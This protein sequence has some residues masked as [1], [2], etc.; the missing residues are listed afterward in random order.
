MRVSVIVPVRW[1]HPR[2]LTL[3]DALRAQAGAEAEL[4]A[5]VMDSGRGR[6]GDLDLLPELAHRAHLITAAPSTPAAVR[7]LAATQAQGEFLVFIDDDCVP[8]ADWLERLLAAA[9][10]PSVGAV[11]G[12]VLPAPAT[13]LTE[14]Y[15]GAYGLPLPEDAAVYDRVIPFVSFGHSANLLVRRS[16]FNTLGGFAADWPTG[17]DHDF[18]YRLIKAGHKL[19]FVPAAAVRHFHRATVGGML[20]QAY[21]YGRG[22]VRLLKRHWPKQYLCFAPGKPPRLR[23]SFFTIWLDKT[24]VGLQRKCFVWIFLLVAA[25]HAPVRGLAAVLIAGFVYTAFLVWWWRFSG[26]L[27]RRVTTAGN[28]LSTGERAMLPLL[29]VAREFALSYGQRL[30]GITERV[31]V[32]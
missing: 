14:K 16:V 22:Q 21:G 6:A 26:Q 32:I 15:L 29:H 5:V 19:A 17:E 30:Q 28:H 25:A 11:A 9:A 13:T 27:A 7:N 4:L 10:D 12:G 8:A 20:R 3:L 31:L 1:S 24:A 2:V 18:C 23:P